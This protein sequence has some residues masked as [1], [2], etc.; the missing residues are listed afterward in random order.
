MNHWLSGLCPLSGIV[1]N[2]KKRFGKQD[3]LPTS[4]EGKEIPT[5][6]CLLELS[7]RD[8]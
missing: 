6:L 4:D 8:G 1:N 7:S 2:K 3:V 5:L